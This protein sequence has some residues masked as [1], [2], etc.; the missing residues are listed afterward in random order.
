MVVNENIRVDGAGSG[1]NE[2]AG[3]NPTDKKP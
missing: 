3:E 2:V 1:V